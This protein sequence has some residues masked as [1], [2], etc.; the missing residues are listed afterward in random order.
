MLEFGFSSRERVSN[1]TIQLF[2]SKTEP[3]GKCGPLPDPIT[4][5]VKQLSKLAEQQS[6]AMEMSRIHP[7]T[8]DESREFDERQD[9]ILELLG[10][11][12]ALLP[13]KTA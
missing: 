9:Q 3:F 12:A 13:K 2:S 11:L 4:V 7:M 10:E 8:S 5:L 1:Q 6:A